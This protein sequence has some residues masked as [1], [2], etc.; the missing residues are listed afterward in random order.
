MQTFLELKQTKNKQNNSSTKWD[1]DKS[2]PR[3]NIVK[4]EDMKYKKKALNITL[5]KRYDYLQ[6]NN[7][8]LTLDFSRT[9][10]R[11][12]VF[13][14]LLENGC[15]SRILYPT[16]LSFKNEGNMNTGIQRPKQF[17]V[18]KNIQRIYSIE[19]QSKLSLKRRLSIKKKVST[20]FDKM[21][22]NVL[23]SWL[24]KIIFLL[25]SHHNKRLLQT[26]LF[27]YTWKL[28]EMNR[29]L[30]KI[31]FIKTETKKNL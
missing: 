26:T 11:S 6:R 9:K 30:K 8:W 31:Q 28:D 18:E 4:L 17:T 29:F 10:A 22:V 3:C 20:K 2:T 1:K 5:E 24:I 12:N 27:Q 16:K 21:L 23:N 19:K 15:P 13:K 14:V 25:N 7:N